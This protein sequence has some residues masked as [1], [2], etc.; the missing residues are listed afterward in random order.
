MDKSERSSF[1]AAAR[2]AL[3]AREA[4]EIVRR[5]QQGFGRPIISDQLHG[6]RV[7][8]VGKTIKW[9]RGWRFFTDFLIDHLKD[10]I[11]RPWAIQ[12]QRESRPHP[13]FDWLTT[14]NEVA[15]ESRSSGGRAF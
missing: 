2:A 5:Y 9:S 13:I 1:E 6:Y 3:N 11:G 12:A 4:A 10:T 7:V 15:A 14:M 8:A